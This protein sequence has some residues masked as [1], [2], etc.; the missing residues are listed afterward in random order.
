LQFPAVAAKTKHEKDG[1]K[2]NEKERET[3]GMVERI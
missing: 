2:D 3:N 1:C